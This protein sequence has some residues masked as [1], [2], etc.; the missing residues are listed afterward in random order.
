MYFFIS[1]IVAL[2][3]HMVVKTILGGA[4]PEIEPERPIMALLIPEHMTVQEKTPTQRIFLILTNVTLWGH[5][6]VKTILG[7]HIQKSSRNGR[8]WHSSSL[9]T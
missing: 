1:T 6:V 3:G 7:E 4:Y 8:L 9:N 2:S 5:M